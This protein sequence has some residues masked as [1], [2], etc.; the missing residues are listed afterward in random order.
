M[1]YSYDSKTGIC[2]FE[3]GTVYTIEEML[4]ISRQ[5]LSDADMDA[6]HKIKKIFAGELD[7]KGMYLIK[8]PSRM[9][10]SAQR[11]SRMPG[12]AQGPSRMPGSFQDIGIQT[13]LK[14]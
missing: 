1:K 4:F 5:K 3:D 9:P 2:L 10:G 11:P 12:S 13:T 14:L 6:I 8:R 7:I